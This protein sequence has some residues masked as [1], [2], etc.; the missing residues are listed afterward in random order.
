MALLSTDPSA[1][2]YIGMTPILYMYFQI[3]LIASREQWR[4]KYAPNHLLIVIIA[5]TT[6]WP[7]K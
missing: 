6:R 5:R 2:G 1:S 4:F 7:N 3:V